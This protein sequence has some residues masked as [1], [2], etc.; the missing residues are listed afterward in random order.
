MK[1]AI[2]THSRRTE[3]DR[4]LVDKVSLRDIA[5][6]TGTTKSALSRHSSHIAVALT[7]AKEVEKVANAETLLEQVRGLVQRTTGIM[8]KAEHAGNL[9]TALQAIRE[10]RGCMELLGKLSGELQAKA[11]VAV[12]VSA[13]AVA[14]IKANKPITEYSEDEMALKL[15]GQFQRAATAEEKDMP[16]AGRIW[17]RVY[18]EIRTGPPAPWFSPEILPPLKAIPVSAGRH[19]REV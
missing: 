13:T 17:R 18:F 15:L 5:G 11:A 8:E 4:L 7:A 3:I 19:E 9:Q 14:E 16:K 2:C 12:A 6:Q 1:C 10:M